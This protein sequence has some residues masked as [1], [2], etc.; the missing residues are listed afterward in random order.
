MPENWGPLDGWALSVD[1]V[2][3]GYLDDGNFTAT[4]GS[5]MAL[6]NGGS[7]LFGGTISQSF[8]TVVGQWYQLDFDAGILAGAASR[9]QR[10]GVLVTGIGPLLSDEVVLS[11]DS[12]PAA[13]WGSQNYTF[14]ADATTTTLTFSDNSVLGEAFQS[15]LLVDHVSVRSEERRVG[16]ECTTR[17]SP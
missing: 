13:Q 7:D 11:A 2:P 10:L 1:P 14:L 5:R 3:F 15:D 17:W 12:G 9:V 8:T 6:L 16:K 4:D